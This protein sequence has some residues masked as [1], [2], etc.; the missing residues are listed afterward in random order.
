MDQNQHIENEVQRRT[1]RLTHAHLQEVD[2][3]KTRLREMQGSLL[4]HHALVQRLTGEPLY[5]ATL[6]RTHNIPNL[7]AYKVND[8]IVVVDPE[9]PHF[10]QTGRIVSSSP[11]VN[12]EGMVT[13][14]LE[15]RDQS[16][17]DF[18]IGVVGTAQVRLVEKDDGTYAVISVDG[19]P[20]EVRGIPDLD[21][22][23][24][25]P[26]KIKADTK[27][28]ISRGYDMPSGHIC[29]VLAVTDKGIEIEEK[30]EKR[31]VMNPKGFVVEEGDRVVADAGFF[32]VIEK[33]E[34][35]SRQ[36]YKLTNDVSLSWDSIG[37]LDL[38]KAQCQEAIELPFQ[39]PELFSYYGM[40][41][42]RGVLLYGPPGCGKTLL[43]KAAANAVA[44]LHGKSATETGYIY[45]KSPEILDKWVGNTEAE[46]REL[47]ERG[48]RH[49]RE[50]HY[51]A[52]LAFDEFDAIAPQRGT[53]RSSDVADTIVPMFLGEMDGID[54]N[55]TRENPI[56][57]VM[58]NRADILDPAIT[59]PGRISKHIKIERPDVD[60]SMDILKIHSAKVPFHK[61]DSKLVILS[62]VCQDLFSKT[63]LLYRVNNEHDFTLGDAVNG[64]MLAAIVEDAK[65]N[66]LKRDLAD[67]TKTGVVLE[68]FRE[69]VKK[70][71]REQRGM[72][73]SYD[74]QDF[75]E[76]LGIQP[77]DMQIERCFGAA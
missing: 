68:D 56:V 1:S 60:G 11:V 66:A 29:R 51:P 64:A 2:D 37:G 25:D 47:F 52:I 73:H 26:V 9:S 31:L 27:Q 4:K 59:R 36:R 74:L 30:G 34:R 41:K 15:D 18:R 12:E 20:W 6:L 42:A 17:A 44:N 3:L 32:V 45:V 16:V 7:D 13:V 48:R 69:S 33:L 58:T 40:E 38:A 72:N 70:C 67:R 62:V 53:R 54:E 65:M 23:V 55:Q 71:F 76:K 35:D 49:F 8:N 61:E 28:I 75:A 10:K 19:K 22:T 63:K 50:H 57:F 21:M 46:I 14:E 77:R 5:F 24:G 39:Q 43:A